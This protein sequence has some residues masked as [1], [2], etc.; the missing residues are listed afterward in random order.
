MSFN[1]FRD[2]G[3]FSYYAASIT[4]SSS[5]L[6][7]SSGPLMMGVDNGMLVEMMQV[8]A[9]TLPNL[10]EFGLI[11]WAFALHYEKSMPQIAFDAQSGAESKP[12]AQ[13]SLLPPNP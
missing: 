3:R 12:K 4:F 6:W 13:S 10:T 9:E 11:T 2:N 5:P 8:E 7:N 1:V